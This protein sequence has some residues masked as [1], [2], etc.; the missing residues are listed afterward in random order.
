MKNRRGVLKK[1]HKH[2][3]TKRVHF[4]LKYVL[5]TCIVLNFNFMEI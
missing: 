4:L 3:I 1:K 2:K 5:I